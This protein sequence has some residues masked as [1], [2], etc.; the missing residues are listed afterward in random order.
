M[1][2]MVGKSC[3]VAGPIELS[4]TRCQSNCSA[5]SRRQR[6]D[7]VMWIAAVYVPLI[8]DDPKRRDQIGAVTAPAK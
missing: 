1:A 4:V 8:S 6:A 2:A 5:R 7:A 3:V